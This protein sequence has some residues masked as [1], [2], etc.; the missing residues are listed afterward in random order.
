LGLKKGLFQRSFVYVYR[1]VWC[2]LLNSFFGFWSWTCFI[3]VIWNIKNL[4][5]DS[6]LCIMSILRSQLDAT[7]SY[8]TGKGTIF[9]WIQAAKLKEF[10]SYCPQMT[11]L[12]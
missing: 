11:K 12:Y 6:T 8:F 9:L 7:K 3:F 5:T 4:H 2:C 1:L 10:C